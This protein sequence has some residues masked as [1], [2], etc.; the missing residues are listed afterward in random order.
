MPREAVP[1]HSPTSHPVSVFALS[2][3][4][5]RTGNSACCLSVFCSQERLGVRVHSENPQ[6]FFVHLFPA[7]FNFWVPWWRKVRFTLEAS[8]TPSLFYSE[9]ISS[10]K[11]S[12]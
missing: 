3:R 4:T 8:P 2:G 11:Q 12:V 10:M 1:K 6:Q 7:C 5:V 9:E